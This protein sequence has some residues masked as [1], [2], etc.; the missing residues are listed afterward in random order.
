MAMNDCSTT[1]M[2]IGPEQRQA[3]ASPL[4]LEIIGLFTGDPLRPVGEVKS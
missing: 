3:L 4:R 2:T 1:A